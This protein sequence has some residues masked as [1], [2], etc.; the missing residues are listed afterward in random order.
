MPLKR[1]KQAKQP[2]MRWAATL[3]F[4]FALVSPVHRLAMLATTRDEATFV[5]HHSLEQQLL[6]RGGDSTAPSSV[7]EESVARHH[8]GRGAIIK[9]NG[10]SSSKLIHD[11]D[12]G[13]DE[14]E[15]RNHEDRKDD[16]AKTA[17]FI[18]K[19]HKAVNETK[20]DDESIRGADIS[21]PSSKKRIRNVA[22]R[23]SSLPIHS[24]PSNERLSEIKSVADVL[25]YTTNNNS[26][27]DHAA[28]ARE[29]QLANATLRREH[30]DANQQQP[31]LRGSNTSL[32]QQESNTS[33]QTQQQ[34]QPTR[35]VPNYFTNEVPLERLLKRMNLV[36]PYTGCSIAAFQYNLGKHAHP[37]FNDCFVHCGKNFAK[38]RGIRFDNARELVQENDTIFVQF[39]KLDHF[40]NKTMQEIDVNYVILSGNE[41]KVDPISK[42]TFDAVVNNPHVI[43]WFMQ[44]MDVYSHDLNH[45]KVRVK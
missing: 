15:R 24:S 38:A 10:A 21:P 9:L 18:G 5:P 8:H 43:H 40:V 17:T 44:N 30:H 36:T 16:A 41:Q 26:A 2:W 29:S 19:N 42:E 13:S 34:Q 20:T 37:E 6:K 14:S 12:H 25:R 31:K 22:T 28:L 7:L 39:N 3:V 27:D 1:R 32:L 33:I 45:H 23:N 11:D 4:S 35:H